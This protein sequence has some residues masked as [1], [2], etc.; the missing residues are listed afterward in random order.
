MPVDAHGV[1]MGHT[2]LV[3]LQSGGNIRMRL[4][5]DI[6]VDANADRRAQSH[7]Q[8]HAGQ[9][10]KFGFAFDIEATNACGQCLAH[11]GGCLADA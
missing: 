6:W 8:C 5:I 7:G 9:H 4:R 1:F 11:F 2:E 10:V 3:A